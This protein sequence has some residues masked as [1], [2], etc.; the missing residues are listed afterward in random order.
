[1]RYT[2]L[3]IDPFTILGVVGGVIPFPHHNQSPRNTYTVAMA[4]QAMGTVA[5]NQYERMDGLIYSLVYPQKPLVK[6][7]TLD[8]L[9][10]DNIPGGQ[11]AVIAVMSY[12]GYDIEDA[13][14]LNKAAIDRGFGRCMVLRKHQTSIRRYANGSMDR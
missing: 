7:R 4:K 1:M 9:D 14:V 10:F 13:V 8:I 3:E 6:S 2:H 11:N 5:L 12:S